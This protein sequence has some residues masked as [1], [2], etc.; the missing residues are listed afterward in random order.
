[1]TVSWVELDPVTCPPDISICSTVLSSEDFFIV[2]FPLATV[3]VSLKFNTIL[4]L[5]AISVAL[6]AGVEEVRVG[7]VTSAVVKLNSVVELMPIYE[8]PWASSNAVA[9]IK[10]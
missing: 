5:M 2:M 7:L 10:P 3:T 1:M 6:S 9:S 8:P 4:E